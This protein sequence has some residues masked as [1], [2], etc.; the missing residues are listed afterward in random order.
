M[1]EQSYANCIY[2]YTC[3][4]SPAKD[5]DCCKD[6]TETPEIEQKEIKL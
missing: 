2:E 6:W 1:A 3:D 5:D 4:W